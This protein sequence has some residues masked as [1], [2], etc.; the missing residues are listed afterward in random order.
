MGVN[1]N[2]VIAFIVVKAVI[3]G[4]SIYDDMILKHVERLTLYYI[5]NTALVYKIIIIY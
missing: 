5:T 1:I 2:V 4:N 3:T